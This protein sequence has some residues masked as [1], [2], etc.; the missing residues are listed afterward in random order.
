MHTQSILLTVHWC[1]QGVAGKP[2]S[3]VEVQNRVSWVQR[4]S[5]AQII[6]CK[7]NTADVQQL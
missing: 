2:T 5:G 1:A 3:A 7:L 6:P 4:V